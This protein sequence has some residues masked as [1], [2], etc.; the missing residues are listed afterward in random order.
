MTAEEMNRIRAEH[1]FTYAYIAEKTGVPLGTVQK[2]LGGITKRPRRETVDALTAFLS[3]FAEPGMNRKG[4]GE[5]SGSAPE[6]TYRT[7]LP[8]LQLREAPASYGSQKCADETERKNSRPEQE[9]LYTLED[10]YALPEREGIRVELID[11]KFY[12]MTAPSLIHQ[13]ILSRLFLQFEQC[14][15][16]HKQECIVMFAPADVQLDNDQYTM[17]EPDLFIVC[18]RSRIRRDRLPGAPDFVVEVLSPS[19]KSKDMTLKTRKYRKAGVREYWMVDPDLKVILQYIFG[20]EEEVHI[21]G[22]H[23]DIPLYISEGLCMIHFEEIWNR[24]SFLYDE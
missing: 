3:S 24:V 5:S 4:S 12:E 10:Y 7:E 13:I 2:V 9:R 19:T 21:Y 8:S 17:V 22:F 14:I 20:E 15:G 11:G 16:Q 6:T 23:D 1:G 18:D